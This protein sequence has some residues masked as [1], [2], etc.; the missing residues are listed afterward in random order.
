M[1]SVTQT[2]WTFFYPDTDYLRS[3]CKLLGQRLLPHEARA[4]ARHADIKTTMNYFV[5][6]R[7]SL[8]DRART[9]SEAVLGASFSA[10]FRARRWKEPKETRLKST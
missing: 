1:T 8:I 5:G 2:F 10:L 9:A 6:L 3:G 4:L 7:E